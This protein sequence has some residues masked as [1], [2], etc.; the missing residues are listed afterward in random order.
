MSQRKSCPNCARPLDGQPL[1]IGRFC[2]RCAEHLDEEARPL[3][4]ALILAGYRTYDSCCGH[5]SRAFSI[6][7]RATEAEAERLRKLIETCEWPHGERW[8][9]DFW[10]RGYPEPFCWC[11][12]SVDLGIDAFDQSVAIAKHL[13]EIL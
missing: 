13:E 6:W 3:V 8:S 7:L 10:S 9:L 1:T 12:C 2:P 11:L 5:G 4:Y